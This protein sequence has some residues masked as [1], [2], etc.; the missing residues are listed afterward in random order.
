[1]LSKSSAVSAPDRK[2]TASPKTMFEMRM[3]T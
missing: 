1:M 3:A 2:V